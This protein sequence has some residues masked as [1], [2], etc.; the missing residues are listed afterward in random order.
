[1]VPSSDSVAGANVILNTSVADVLSNF[2]DMLEKASDKYVAIHRI[3][4]DTWNLHAKVVFNGNGYSEEWLAEAAKRKLP[5]LASLVDALPEMIK[6]ENIK[7]FERHKVLSKVEM[8]SRY[9]IYLEHYS[10][11]TSIEAATM[12]DMARKEIYPT[13]SEFATEL[14]DTITSVKTAAPKANTASQEKI[15]VHVQDL[16][17]KI[18]AETD[19]L[20]KELAH[21]ESDTYKHARHVRDV[22]VPQMAALRSVADELEKITPKELWPFPTYADLLFKL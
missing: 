5:N 22:I 8:E 4:A 10:K 12:V 7:L 15:L 16:L 17:G 13:G 6:P 3:V 11:Q 20:E 21:R 14:A 2:A 19:K 9:E 18:D 1:M